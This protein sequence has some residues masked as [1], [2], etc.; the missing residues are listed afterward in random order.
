MTSDNSKR[1][2]GFYVQYI[3]R[4]IQ[5]REAEGKPSASDI[6]P[7]EYWDERRRIKRNQ[8]QA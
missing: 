4:L 5:R 8:S 6:A 7:A 1:P 3:E 2:K